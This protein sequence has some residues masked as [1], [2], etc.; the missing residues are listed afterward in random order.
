VS[1]L[2]ASARVVCI[3]APIAAGWLVSRRAGRPFTVAATSVLLGAAVFV[4]AYFLEAF[5]MRW[6]GIDEAP[7]SGDIVPI[8]YA[9]LVAAPLEQGLKFAAFAPIFRT[10]RDVTP[11]DG[12]IYA[13]AIALGF[14]SAHNLI[15]LFWQM[16]SGY[17]AVVRAAADV[18]AHCFFAAV[19][20]YALGKDPDRRL[21]GRGFN[22]A[23]LIATLFNG[24]FDNIAFGRQL[25]ALVAIVP[26]LLA[27]GFITFLAAR[28][29]LLDDRPLPSR[30][31]IARR[32]LPAIAPPTMQ[33][34]RAALRRSERPIMVRWIFI[35]ALV[36]TG[37]MT[38]A[39]SLSVF[40]GHRVGLDFA[41]V[42]RGETTAAGTAPLVLLGAAALSAF[43]IGG[44]LVA[45]ASAA[46]SVLE[47]AI[48]AALAIAGVLVLLGLAAPVAV[49]FAV[50]FAPVAFGLACAGAWIGMTR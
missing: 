23:W 29:L 16:G 38:A 12:V 4:P 21:G 10:R 39:L 40:L 18:P 47:P 31:S 44:Y 37:V 50:A 27:I 5:L 13:G 34:M 25:Y 33:A 43:P 8:I 26:I 32:F 22:V 15:Y 24:V 48:G 3:A 6:A 9:L 2:E 14:A 46:R 49:V 30:P 36:T 28:D 45:R 35:G 20:G 7:K 11:L 19:W 41:A 17:G 1:P 42:D